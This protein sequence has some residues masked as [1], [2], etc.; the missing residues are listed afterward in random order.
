M[1]RIY[2][3]RAIFDVNL[4]DDISLFQ[5]V[6]IRHLTIWEYNFVNAKNKLVE[7]AQKALYSVFYKISNIKIPLDLKLIPKS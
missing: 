5:K 2:N 4:L 7:Q 6:N 3:K 1:F